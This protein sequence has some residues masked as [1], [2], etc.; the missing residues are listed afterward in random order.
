M[1]TNVLAFLADNPAA[2]LTEKFGIKEKRHPAFPELMHLVYCQIASSAH[3]GH[4]IVNECRGLILNART[5]EVVSH[6]FHRFYNDGEAVAAPIDWGSARVQ[7]KLDGSL[8]VLYHYAGAWHVATKG[9]PDAGGPVLGHTMTFRE[10]FWSTWGHQHLGLPDLD[11]DFTYVFELTSPLNRVVVAHDDHRLTLLGVRSRV[12]GQEFP[13]SAFPALNPVR[14]HPLGSLV[15]VRAA[16]EVLNPIAAEG[17]VVV[18]RHFNRVKIKSPRYVAIHHLKD[19]LTMRGLLEMVKAG[20]QHEVLAYFPE[21]RAAYEDVSAK[22]DALAAELEADYARIAH[23]E[24]Q[25]DFAL[26][27][28]KTRWSGALFTVRKGGAATIR[29]ALS[30]VPAERLADLIPA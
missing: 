28:V 8:T 17:F 19:T 4:P 11:P 1:A 2:A 27:A 26:E 3:A 6:P 30:K 21:L 29:E 22:F 10:L 20:E 23:I 18:D 13:A 16:A 7:D 5:L 9:S 24:N 14:E 25:K 15:D 12:T